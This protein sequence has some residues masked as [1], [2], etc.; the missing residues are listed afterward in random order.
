MAIQV[1]T[2]GL[3]YQC[4][5][6]YL[7]LFAQSVQR[8]DVTAGGY[9]L[10]VQTL[11]PSDNGFVFGVPD[12]YGVPLCISVP[13]GVDNLWVVGKTAGYDPI[14]ASSA[15]VVP[16]GMVVGEAV[17]VAA[18]QAERLGVRPLDL[19]SDYELIDLIRTV[20]EQ[21]GAY[22]PDITNREPVGPREHM[23]YDAYRLLLSRGLAVG[24]YD[25]EPRLDELVRAIDYIYLL[26]NVGTR[27]LAEHALGQT[28]LASFDV[29]Q[30]PL[31]PELALSM[32]RAAVIELGMC[33]TE[34][35]ELDAGFLPSGFEPG[36]RLTR[37]EM[38]AL[39]ADIIQNAH[40]G[41]NSSSRGEGE[42]AP[43]P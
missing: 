25:N 30:A 35:C 37:G 15:R 7:Q 19:V 39:A 2:D 11:T 6:G 10:D 5:A 12:I 27:F 20:L 4:G 40:L 13:K 41:R 32:T 33:P 1:L 22:L 42:S 18:A 8:P 38:Y 3:S 31:S 34:D 43:S 29:G 36:L 16:L 28:L 24:G 14:A 9:P 26:S 17:G 21:R 23:S